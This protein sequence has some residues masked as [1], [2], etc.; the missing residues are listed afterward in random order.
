MKELVELN[1]KSVNSITF[2]LQPSMLF[3]SA[4]GTL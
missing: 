4:A 2:L 3:A 1:K